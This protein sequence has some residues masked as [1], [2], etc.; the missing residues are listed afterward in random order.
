MNNKW[1]PLEE[2]VSN[3]HVITLKDILSGVAALSKVFASFLKRV[4][5]GFRGGSRGARSTPL[6]LKISFS[7]RILDKLDKFGIPYL[8]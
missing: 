7:W 2:Y 8:S 4:Q 1:R 5:G 3:P 6:R